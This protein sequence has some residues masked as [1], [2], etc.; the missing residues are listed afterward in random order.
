L[1]G[2]VNLSAVTDFS[3]TEAVLSGQTGLEIYRDLA[4]LFRPQGALQM[5]CCPGAFLV[6][7]VPGNRSEKHGMVAQM[8]HSQGLQHIETAKDACG[9]DRCMVFATPRT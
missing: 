6:L 3:P 9:M 8:F 4:S 5:S 1:P 2:N 7:E